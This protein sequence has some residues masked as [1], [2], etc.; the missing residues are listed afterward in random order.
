MRQLHA[1]MDRTS[2]EGRG[3]VDPPPSTAHCLI[4]E[5]RRT[6]APS[7]SICG[8]GVRKLGDEVA[9]VEKRNFK[10]DPVV[11]AYGA[12]RGSAAG[13]GEGEEDGVFF[14]KPPNLDREY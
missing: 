6:G 3:W 11:A 5:E 1:T 12:R 8:E 10:S 13:T 9:R 4:P 2:S 7:C 14:R